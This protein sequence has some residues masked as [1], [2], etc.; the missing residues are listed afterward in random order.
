MN[1]RGL[2][3]LLEEALLQLINYRVADEEYPEMIEVTLPR[4]TSTLVVTVGDKQGEA[5]QDREIYI[6]TVQDANG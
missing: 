6:I 3:L 1:K 4:G 5:E 2:A